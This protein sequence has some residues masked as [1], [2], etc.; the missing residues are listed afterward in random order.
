MLPQSRKHLVWILAVALCAFAIGAQRA[1]ACSCGIRPTVLDAYEDS[2]VVV[3]A[4]ILSVEKAEA[5]PN[6]IPYVDGVRSATV[7]V[8][9]VFKGNVKVRDELVFGQGGGADCIWTFNEHHLGAD[10]L[11][12]VDYPKGEDGL[13]YAVACGRSNGVKGAREDFLYLENMAKLRGK[14][15]ISGTLGGWQNPNLDVAGKRV[16]LIGPKKTYQ[17]K[18]DE[19]G[20]FEIYDVPPGEYTVEPEMPAG[21]KIDPFWLR[22]SPGVDM[23]ETMASDSL[24]RVKIMLEAKRHAVINLIFMIDNELRGKVSGPDGKPLKGVCLNLLLSNGEGGAGFDC[25]NEEGVFLFDSIPAG[26]YVLVANRDGKPTSSQP[27]NTIYYPNVSQKER[28]AVFSIRPGETVAGINFIIPKLFETITVKGVLLYSDGEPVVDEYVYFRMEDDKDTHRNLTEKTDTEGRFSFTILK[29]VKGE[30]YSHDYFYIGE[31]K[32]CP[33]LDDLLKMNGH[34]GTTLET[35]LI[36]IKAEQD[37]YDVEL[38]F[39]FP[40]CKKAN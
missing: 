32:D 37:M 16:R 38:K 17:L 31:F 20:F 6:G 1:R 35:N 39:P 5:N 11:F 10:I 7:R 14:T 36:E 21:W 22:Y 9:K 4:R 30:L 2:E 13:W 24:R 25:T 40:G 12:Y 27:F 15:R 8:E 19:Q 29:G 23:E 18:T 28:A 33:Q 3:I 34:T 26:E